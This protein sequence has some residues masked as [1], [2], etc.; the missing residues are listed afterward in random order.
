MDPQN[1][2]GVLMETSCHMYIVYDQVVLQS[3]ES[4]LQG[5]FLHETK[6]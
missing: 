3:N 1:F 6:S 2:L 5:Y 4:F